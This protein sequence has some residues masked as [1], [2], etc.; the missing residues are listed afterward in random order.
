MSFV[1]LTSQKEKLGSNKVELINIYMKQKPPIQH[2]CKTLKKREKNRFLCLCGVWSNPA[3]PLLL[4]PTSQLA[5]KGPL[6]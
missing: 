2:Q 6:V 4:H 1:I 5:A 3:P